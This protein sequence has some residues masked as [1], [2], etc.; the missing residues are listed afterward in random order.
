MEPKKRSPNTENL[1]LEVSSP[2]KYGDSLFRGI[3]YEYSNNHA[4]LVPSKVTAGILIRLRFQLK[5]MRKII[6]NI[7]CSALEY[8]TVNGINYAFRTS[9]SKN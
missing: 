9:T 1:K 4:G 8:V 6:Q 7:S 2:V 5:N 3:L